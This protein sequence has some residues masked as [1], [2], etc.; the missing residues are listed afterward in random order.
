MTA[1]L[2]IQ[3]S[4]FFDNLFHTLVPAYQPDYA[5]AEQ[6][7]DR[8][9]EREFPQILDDYD[10]TTWSL[11]NLDSDQLAAFRARKTELQSETTPYFYRIVDGR[12]LAENANLIRTGVPQL[13]PRIFKYGETELWFASTIGRTS[14]SIAQG[15]SKRWIFSDGNIFLVLVGTDALIMTRDQMQFQIEM[16]MIAGDIQVY[17][18]GRPLLN[19]IAFP[20]RQSLITRNPK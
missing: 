10:S 13:S 17:Y 3:L 8:Q 12:W 15:I 4:I 1:E 5:G 2:T 16:E 14:L 19:W 11:W 6:A 18:F 20:F 9:L 7:I